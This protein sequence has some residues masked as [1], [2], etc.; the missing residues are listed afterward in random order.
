[1]VKN[2]NKFFK[3]F[4]EKKKNV[5]LSNILDVPI[6]LFEEQGYD[7]NCYTDLEAV[8]QYYRDM[9]TEELGDDLESLEAQLEYIDEQSLESFG[10]NNNYKEWGFNKYLD[11]IRSTIAEYFDTVEV[12]PSSIIYDEESKMILM[13]VNNPQ[14]DMEDYIDYIKY[15]SIFGIETCIGD[16]RKFKYDEEKE[17]IMIPANFSNLNAKY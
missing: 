12:D 3:L 6:L 16:P 10:N 1:M 17:L 9:Y 13:P 5:D 7:G 2:H 8:K 4:E 11:S 14:D 15:K